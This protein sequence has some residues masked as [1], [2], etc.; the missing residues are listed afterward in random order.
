MVWAAAA[1]NLAITSW[2]II[3]MLVPAEALK[4]MKTNIIMA[5][6]QM[7][8][9][10]CDLQICLMTNET[11]LRG[12][13]YQGAGSRENWS[14]E[15]AELSIGGEFKDALTEPGGWTIGMT[16]FGELLPYHENRIYSG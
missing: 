14:R 2:I 10:L 8:F 12:F 13:G 9:I 4:V 3:I 5:A 11:F 7:V 1:A 15:V 6:G 16:G